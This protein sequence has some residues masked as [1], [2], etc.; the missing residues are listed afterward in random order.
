[1]NGNGGRA[2]LTYGGSDEMERP[3]DFCQRWTGQRDILGEQVRSSGTNPGPA[4]LVDHGMSRSVD[5]C[6]RLDEGRRRAACRRCSDERYF[7][8]T[9]QRSVLGCIPGHPSVYAVEVSKHTRSRAAVDALGP[10]E[11]QG[12]PSDYQSRR[13]RN[14]SARAGNAP[15]L[16][17]SRARICG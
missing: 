11:V 4:K 7:A 10:K 14:G 3:I 1:M 16:A 17:P 13:R 9:K 5:R 6:H 15:R 2:P 12:T 8:F